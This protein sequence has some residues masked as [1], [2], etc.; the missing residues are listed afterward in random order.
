MK[1]NLKYSIIV[2]SKRPTKWQL[3]FRIVLMLL[4]IVILTPFQPVGTQ[5]AQIRETLQ[6]AD[7]GT[8]LRESLPGL[9]LWSRMY[10]DLDFG[11]PS[12]TDRRLTYPILKRYNFGINVNFR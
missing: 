1:E 8:A 9:W 10:E 6:G 4:A 7:L 3:L 11:G 12:I 2:S 5:R